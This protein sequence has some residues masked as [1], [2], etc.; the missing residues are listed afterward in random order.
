MPSSKSF[1]L[2]SPTAL[3]SSL[4]HPPP[5]FQFL[6]Y[7]LPLISPSALPNLTHHRL[8]KTSNTAP[9]PYPPLI[10]STSPS[11]TPKATPPPSLTATTAVS[12]PG[13]SPKVA[14]SHCRT[15]APISHCLPTTTQIYWH[16]TNV[17]TT[18]L[19]RQW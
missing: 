19:S 8:F 15:A 1:A 16:Q 5:K 10:Q 4:T 6:L 13:S 18:Q 9:L 2:H 3:G 17:H 7:S 11:R 14:V 12:A